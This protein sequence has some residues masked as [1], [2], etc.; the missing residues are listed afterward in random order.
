MEPSLERLQVLGDFHGIESGYHD[1]WGAFHPT[2]ASTYLRMLSALG[3]QVTTSED[4]EQS[5]EA[6][7]NARWEEWCEPAVVEECGSSVEIQ[8]RLPAAQ[9]AQSCLWRLR[10]EDGLEHHGEWQ[11][12]QLERRDSA[13]RG[14][15]EY[16]QVAAV[17][18][19]DL[20]LGYHALT[21]AIPGWGESAMRVI[22]APSKCID[23]VPRPS[24]RHWGVTAQLYSIRSPAQWGIGDFG[25]LRRLATEVAQDGG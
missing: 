11:L 17:L 5:I 9:L 3:H 6:A 18:P 15:I 2:S 10:T 1:I 12:C 25:D 4:V 8:L 24:G 20:P 14:E 19:V 7:L 13:R 22:V 16:H 21:L 23:V